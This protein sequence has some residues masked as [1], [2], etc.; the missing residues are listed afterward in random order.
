V[1]Y[2]LFADLFAK[3]CAAFCFAELEL[4]RAPHSFLLKGNYFI[5]FSLSNLTGLNKYFIFMD[6]RY[7][8][9]HKW[10]TIDFFPICVGITNVFR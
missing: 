7:S 8:P 4:G 10:L 6:M 1:G 9:G 2:K 5:S 3:L